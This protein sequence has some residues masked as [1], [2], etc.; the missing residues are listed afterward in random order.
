MAVIQTQIRQNI[1]DTTRKLLVKYGYNSL[2]MRK[3]ASDAGCALGTIYL[4]F[5][6]KD[7]LIHSLIDEGFELMYTDICEDAEKYKA[8][9]QK[10]ESV[11]RNYIS[12]GLEYP[13]YYEIMYLLHPERMKRYPREKFRRARRTFDLVAKILD[14]LALNRGIIL[15]D[16]TLMSYSI[17]ATLHGV[18]TILLAKRLDKK[19]DRNDLIDNVIQR[20]MRSVI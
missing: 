19:I 6:N 7:V 4:Y 3:I 15:Q 14:D 20:I 18:V 8:P 11:C 13:E 17:W 16:S 5:D 9:Q 2:S 10:L 1:L 12:F